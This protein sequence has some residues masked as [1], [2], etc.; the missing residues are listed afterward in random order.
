[1]RVD[2]G[3]LCRLVAYL[4]GQ[5]REEAKEEGRREGW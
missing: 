3:G 2:K 4:I 5:I 1:M